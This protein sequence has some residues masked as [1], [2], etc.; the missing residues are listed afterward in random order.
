MCN[1][2]LEAFIGY[3]IDEKEINLVA[4]YVA[5]LPDRQQIELY[6]RLLKGLLVFLDSC[7][8]ALQST[9]YVNVTIWR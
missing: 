2:V 3:L 4:I 8:L 7:F 9:F 6:A 5:T 1:A